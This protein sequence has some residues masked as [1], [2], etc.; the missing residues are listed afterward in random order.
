MKSDD[1]LKALMISSEAPILFAR[2]CEIFIEE[3]TLRAW[4]HS[5]ESNR[6]T[7]QKIDITTAVSDSDMYDFLIDVV[8]REIAAASDTAEQSQIPST[9]QFASHENNS[10]AVYTYALNTVASNDSYRQVNT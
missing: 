5:E 10:D 3:L 7:L 8:P 2:A 1:E 4:M 9:E 6:R